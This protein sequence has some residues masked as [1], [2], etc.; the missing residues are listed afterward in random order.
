MKPMP[1]FWFFDKPLLSSLRLSKMANVIDGI[2]N[3]KFFI[4]KMENGKW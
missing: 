3:G 1:F 4:G 2:V